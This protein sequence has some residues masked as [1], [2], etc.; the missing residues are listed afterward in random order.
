MGFGVGFGVGICVGLAIG[1]CVGLG[2]GENWRLRYTA[3]A[4]TPSVAASASTKALCLA[5]KD[6][7]VSPRKVRENETLCGA[8]LC[9]HDIG[10]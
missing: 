1:L 8:K 10:A 6:S 4:F 2:V 7:A 9:A 3:L 5:P